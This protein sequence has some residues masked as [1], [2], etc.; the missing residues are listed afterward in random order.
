[1]LFIFLLNPLKKY[2]ISTRLLTVLIKRVS[3]IAQVEQEWFLQKLH[4]LPA[5]GIPKRNGC[6]TQTKT[7]EWEG[8]I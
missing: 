6:M 8:R 2:K 4:I 1:M 5:G 7:E 3:V